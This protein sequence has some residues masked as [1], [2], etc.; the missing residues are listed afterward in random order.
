MLAPSFLSPQCSPKKTHSIMNSPKPSLFSHFMCTNPPPVCDWVGQTA[1]TLFVS[2]LQSRGCVCWAENA[3]CD[4]KWRRI[5]YP[6]SNDFSHV[7]ENTCEE[8]TDCCGSARC[9]KRPAVLLLSLKESM[10]HSHLTF[11]GIFW[12][13]H[14]AQNVVA[15]KV[16][17]LCCL[18]LLIQAR[19][20][21][22]IK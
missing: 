22:M 21:K 13:Q 5:I 11:T 6:L 20:I 16:H 17:R 15:A 18:I 9:S 3:E 2:S 4:K 10:V 19:E 1:P 12:N 7:Y 14:V 8:R